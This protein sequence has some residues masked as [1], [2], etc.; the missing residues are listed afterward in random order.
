[1]AAEIERLRPGVRH[2]AKTQPP[3]ETPIIVKAEAGPLLFIVEG[4]IGKWQLQVINQGDIHLR[5]VTLV[6]R[7]PPMITT[8]SNRIFLGAIEA[9]ETISIETPL[10]IRPNQQTIG[11][12][13]SLPFEVVCRAPE[14]MKRYA[15][16]F[17]IPI[18]EGESS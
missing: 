9:G 3:E 10:I 14:K 16:T 13:S 2:F 12:D 18:E 15:G 11:K 8:G 6:L 17:I 1:L 5:Q 4:R 7:P